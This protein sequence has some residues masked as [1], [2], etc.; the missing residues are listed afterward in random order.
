MRIFSITCM[1]YQPTREHFIQYLKIKKVVSG[2]KYTYMY[3]YN[4][5]SQRKTSLQKNKGCNPVA[6]YT[7]PTPHNCVFY[8]LSLLIITLPSHKQQLGLK[9]GVADLAISRLHRTALI[10]HHLVPRKMVGTCLV[11]FHQ[12]RDIKPWNRLDQRFW[13]N[14]CFYRADSSGK[15]TGQANGIRCDAM[16]YESLPVTECEC[17]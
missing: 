8:F 9:M 1:L 5:A 11:C 12:I 17:F 14:A 16:R 2:L 6:I 3:T 13:Q 7:F 15:E 10:C 4:V